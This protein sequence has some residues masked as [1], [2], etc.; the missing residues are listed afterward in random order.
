MRPS[1]TE[2]RLV[3]LAL[4]ALVTGPGLG[5]ARAQTGDVERQDRASTAEAATFLLVPLGARSVG[6][7]GAAVAARGDVEG[8]LWNPASTSDLSG[9][10]VFGH[11]S[12]D[13]GTSSIVIGGVIA[14][15]R[16][17]I[18]AAYHRFDLGTVDARD[19][20]NQPLGTL[21]PDDAALIV[22]AA[23][24]VLEGLAVGA[25]A[26]LL[27]LSSSCGGDCTTLDETATGLALDFGVVGSVPGVRGVDLGLVLRNV[28][29]SVGYGGGPKDPLPTR[30]RLGASAGLPALF[31]REAWAE[32][33]LDLLA[34][35]DVQETFSELDDL[36]VFSGVEAT[37]RDLLRLRVGYAW[38]GTGRTGLSAGLGIHWNRLDFDLA[39][40]FDDFSRFDS[41]APFQAS[42]GYRF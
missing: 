22:T 12:N 39:R 20:A 10:A 33:Q 26:R 13:F 19:A 34:R 42:V 31:G 2:L 5:A 38:T 3:A 18:G 11:L 29:A 8:V 27:R 36:D 9:S 15:G 23:A 14:A 16:V 1:P 37:W 21:E 24:P 32:G 35:V 30:I 17:R 25:G 4:A 40:S 28:G 6:M 41:D 7:G